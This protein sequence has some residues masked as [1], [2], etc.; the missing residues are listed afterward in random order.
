MVTPTSKFIEVKKKIFFVWVDASAIYR[1]KISLDL[2]IWASPHIL[3]FDID[4]I[5]EYIH[6]E[7]LPKIQVF[8]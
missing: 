5:E 3:R 4:Y 1:A 8:I 2:S 7:I 6:T